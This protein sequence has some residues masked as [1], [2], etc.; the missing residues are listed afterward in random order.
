MAEAPLGFLFER[1]KNRPDHEAAVLNGVSTSYG[2]LLDAIARWT[3]KFVAADLNSGAVVQLKGDFNADAV[4]CLLALLERR[5]I[6]IPVARASLEKAEEFAQ[7]GEAEFIIDLIDGETLARTDVAASHAYYTTL[8]EAQS[9]GLVIFSSGSTGVSKGA[10]HNAEYLLLKFRTP[11][12]DMRTLAF[13]LFDHIGGIDTLLYCLSNGSTLI[14]TDGRDPESVCK[15]IEKH[16]VEVL[17]TAPSFLN[18]LLIAGAHQRYDLSS[19]KVI[20]YG[21]EMMPQ[22]T[23]ERCADAFPGVTLMQKY[24]TTEF[25]AMRSHSRDNRSR[26]VKLGGEGY[27]TRVRDGKLEVRSSSAMLGYLN[28]PSPFTD[29]GYFMTGDCV[30]VDGDYFRFEGRDSDIIN[31]GGQKVY[32]AEVENLIKELPEVADVAIYGQPNPLLGAVV[33]CRLQPSDADMESG[34]LRSLVRKHLAGKVESYKI[35][36]KYFVTRESMTTDRFK[37]VRS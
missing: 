35:P 26:W 21:A 33:C 7:V 24:G 25:G 9:P 22:A 14:F 6:V 12:R 3:E 29:D 11:R 5:A 13:L 17:P 31:V 16:K 32:P 20:T 34:A 1:F 8:R 37:K 10:V 23:L 28:A 18:M 15:L 2:D 30:E 19:L 36:Q 4:A 27:E